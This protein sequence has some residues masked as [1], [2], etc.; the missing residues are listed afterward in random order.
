MP[1]KL[2]I[3]MYARY[4]RNMFNGLEISLRS[5]DFRLLVKMAGL[6]IHRPDKDTGVV[7]INEQ[8]EEM[9]IPRKDTKAYERAMAGSG[10]KKPP[11]SRR[12]SVE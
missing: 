3:E 6:H 4:S 9:P 5:S 11:V 12:G 1:K 10:R 8:E 7:R 2:P